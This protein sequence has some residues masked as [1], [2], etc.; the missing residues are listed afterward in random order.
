MK[1]KIALTVIFICSVF[2]VAYA[3]Q[4]DF[5]WYY[6]TDIGRG[7]YALADFDGYAGVDIHHVEDIDVG[8]I[9]RIFGRHNHVSEVEKL[10]KRYTWL[11]W[12]AISEYDFKEG[13]RYS[14]LCMDS[15]EAQIAFLVVLTITDKGNSFKW[16]AFQLIER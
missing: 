4:A 5:K 15:L 6:N 10:P 3:Q 1:K 11:C 7:G 8:D 14:V 9:Q 12:Q 2:I 16:R 13:E